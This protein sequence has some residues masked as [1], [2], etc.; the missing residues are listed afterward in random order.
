[1]STNTGMQSA[2]NEPERPQFHFTPQANWMNDPNGLLYYQGEY[3]LFYQHHPGSISSGPMHWG[4]A[5]SHN[6]V[7]WTH[8]PIA[9][10]PDEQGDAWSG[11]AVVDANNTSGFFPG[12]SGLAA[13]YTG[14]H[15]VPQQQCLAYSS[16]RGRTWTKYK[17]NPVIAN[18]GVNDFRDP[19]V[20]WYEPEQRWFM[21]VAGGQVRFY[22]SPDL[23]SWRL[24]SQLDDHTECP[25]LFPLAI[26]G[27]PNKQKWVLSLGG[28]FYYVGSFDGHIFSKE[29][30]LLTTDYGSDFYAA[31]SWSDIPASDGRRIWLGWMTDL[32]YAPV[33][34]ATSWRGTM[35]VARSL[36]LKTIP[37]G[38]RLV[39]MPIRELEQ[40]RSEQVHLDRSELTPGT[41]LLAD[42]RSDT[43]DIVA[44]FQPGSGREFG[45]KLRVG[46]EEQTL[47]G[48][49]TRTS[50]FFVDRTQSGRS[51]FNN[52]FAARHETS[53]LLKNNMLTLRILLDRTSIEVFANDGEV[54]I[55]DLIFP[56]VSSQGIELYTSGGETILHSLDLYH[57]S[58]AWKR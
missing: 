5:V 12:G 26:D 16:D 14:A 55:S 4:H 31:Q 7:H 28:R 24:E 57:M 38:L 32:S 21:I 51:D 41:N 8:L 1:M 27:D 37:Q 48:Y 13:L 20:F 9:L 22:S 58:S 50:R 40:L 17:Y 47:V 2:F 46:G 34:P 18:P 11:S 3:H 25:D 54:V 49:D 29:S 43:L 45:F 56:N 42:M 53:L 33:I 15:T 19:R 6:L 36:G 10:Y 44:S 39:Q 35:S 30:D 23:K 52:R